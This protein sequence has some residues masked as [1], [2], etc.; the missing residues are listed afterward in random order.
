M[1]NC[2]GERLEWILSSELDEIAFGIYSLDGKDEVLKILKI[3][4]KKEKII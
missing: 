2:L 1:E 3:Y 4:L